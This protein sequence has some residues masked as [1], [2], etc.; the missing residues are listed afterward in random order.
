MQGRDAY[1]RRA[2]SDAYTLLTQADELTALADDDLEKLAWSAGL[3]GHDSE[4]LHLLERL[5]QLR[6]DAGPPRRA[7]FTAFWIG[8][9]M[10]ALQEGRSSAWLARARR[11]VELEPDGCAEQG[12][13]L[14]PEVIRL[15]AMGELDAGLACADTII[16]LGER[17]ADPNVL[18]FGRVYRGRALV[19][20]GKIEQGLAL[21]DEVML[22]ATSG[23]LAPIVT[24]LVYCMVIATFQQVFAVR[25][26]REWTDAL[27]AWCEAQPQLVPFAGTCLVHRA[28]IKQLSGAWQEASEEARRCSERP[29]FP[30]DGS[31]GEALYQQAEIERLRGNLEQAEES[32]RRASEKGREP[33][34]GL[35]LLRLAQGR[36]DAAQSAIQRVL[37]STREDLRRAQ[38]LPAYVEIM[39]A[40]GALE[41]AENACSELE[42]TAEHF[43]TEILSA[44]AKHARGALDLARGD[45]CAALSR[46]REAFPIWQQLEAP[47]LAA[48][49]RVLI[50][51]ACAA[52]SDCDG[53]ELELSAARAVFEKLGAARDLA[54]LDASSQPALKQAVME[55][56]PHGPRATPAS[57]HPL[58]ARE[59]E[60]LQLLAT[61]KTN[62][63]IAKALFVR[64]KTV[65]RHVSNIFNKL[66]VRTR[67]AATAYAFRHGLA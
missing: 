10:M 57:E 41:L 17:F 63:E 18:A 38:F 15:I 22:A 47:Y 28:E 2:W 62:K 66:D 30:R 5:Y 37:D 20:M 46:L 3:S 19:R 44:L 49:V 54:E 53:A 65:D 40:A 32:Y 11:L 26:A 59:L 52:V 12:Y 64:E 67:A 48:R 23:E 43:D 58:S 24:G 36:T 7:A 1:A 50:A 29:A 6:A 16:E 33:Q 8:F 61:G 55:A 21:S 45:A 60:V 9:R 4:S 34:P 14:L 39:L 51:R 56:M 25:R 35:A 27:A 13:L 42:R 31:I